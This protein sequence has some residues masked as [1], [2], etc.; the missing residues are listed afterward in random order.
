MSL[1]LHPTNVSGCTEDPV[2]Q[3]NNLKHDLGKMF[4][5]STYAKNVLQFY[6]MHALG[7]TALYVYAHY[8][9]S[10]MHVTRTTYAHPHHITQVAV[11]VA[12]TND[13]KTY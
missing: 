3:I 10:C 6:A 4:I 2:T 11:A 13:K 8:F 7:P 12:G 5:Y 9:T 1:P